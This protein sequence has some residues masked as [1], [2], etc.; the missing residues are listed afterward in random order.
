[1]RPSLV[2]LVAVGCF[3]LAIPAGQRHGGGGVA[4]QGPDAVREA[5]APYADACWHH[6]GWRR[7]TSLHEEKDSAFEDG[8][9]AVILLP[10]D[11]SFVA[12][13]P[14][15][16]L[17]ELRVLGAIYQRSECRVHTHS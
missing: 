3:L 2:L 5:L 1:M 15:A 10:T 6:G 13:H 9:A 11:R 8:E 4:A 17:G 14:E 12:C 16:S 7:G